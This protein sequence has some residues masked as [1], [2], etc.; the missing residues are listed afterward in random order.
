MTLYR[1]EHPEDQFGP[2]QR[3]DYGRHEREL[4]AYYNMPRPD[5][6]WV[7]GLKWGRVGR[8][9][10]RFACRSVAELYTW[11]TAPDRFQLHRCGYV[12]AEYDCP[13]YAWESDSEGSQALFDLKAA[14]CVAVQPLIESVCATTN[15]LTVT[16][17]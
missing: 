12:L 11:F 4:D 3:D 15:A 16:T 8:R 9:R 6:G 2:F 10:C 1:I 5:I 14:Q 17:N 7:Y 13:E